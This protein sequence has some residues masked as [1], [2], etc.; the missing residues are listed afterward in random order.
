MLTSLQITSKLF[1]SRSMKSRKFM[2]MDLTIA[3]QLLKLT[4]SKKQKSMLTLV[5]TR[6]QVPKGKLKFCFVVWIDQLL[7]SR[8]IFTCILVTHSH[9][10]HEHQTLFDPTLSRA[11]A[12]VARKVS[13]LSLWPS[14]MNQGTYPGDFV[15]LKKWSP[16]KP[17][18]GANNDK[19][20]VLKSEI[21]PESQDASLKG[22]ANSQVGLFGHIVFGTLRK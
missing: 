22:T 10:H 17:F 5:S 13:L 1:L 2:S 19:L 18:C 16:P 4:G 12:H 8:F 20:R 3:L 15:G 9:T 6:V 11:A 14:I 7:C 21:A